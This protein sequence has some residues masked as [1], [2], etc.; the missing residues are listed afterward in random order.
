MRKT[1]GNHKSAFKDNFFPP[2]DHVGCKENTF[3][4]HS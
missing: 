4:S 1:S 2:V 3:G